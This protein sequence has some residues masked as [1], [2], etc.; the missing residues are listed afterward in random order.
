VAV[1]HG[2]NSSPARIVNSVVTRGIFGS[3][4]L[5]CIKC[6]MDKALFKGRTM[7]FALA[8][9]K[10]S[11]TLSNTETARI[12]KRQLLR[13]ATSVGA[14][15]RAACSAKSRAGFIA[16]MAIVQEECDESLNGHFI[17]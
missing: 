4:K 11:R 10:A 1:V 6:F 17:D 3:G 7:S 8:M 2:L 9:I 15:H 12:I 5:F 16:K 14:N 13:S